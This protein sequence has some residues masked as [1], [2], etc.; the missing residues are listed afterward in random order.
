M[1]SR[2][3]S[4]PKMPKIFGFDL[5]VYSDCIEYSMEFCRQRLKAEPRLATE[6]KAA[7]RNFHSLKIIHFDIK[8]E[9]ICFSEEQ[10]RYVFID[11]G[12]HRVIN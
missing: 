12:L 7:L 3:K 2:L 4:G 10:G 8:P 9:N 5:L 6:L 1:V 11:L